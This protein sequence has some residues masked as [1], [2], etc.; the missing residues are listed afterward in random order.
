MIELRADASD[1]RLR[2]TFPDSTQIICLYSS[3]PKSDIWCALAIHGFHTTVEFEPVFS[4][5]IRRF[6]DVSTIST[7]PVVSRKVRSTTDYTSIWSAESTF[8]A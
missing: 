1:I 5:R 6:S 8:S 7:G 2:A 3:S 4:T